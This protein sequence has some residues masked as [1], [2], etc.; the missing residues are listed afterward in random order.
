MKLK[1]ALSAGILLAATGLAGH[2][3]TAG[4]AL[5]AMQLPGMETLHAATPYQD[6]DGQVP[7]SGEYF[8]PLF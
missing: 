6:N 5:R 1:H 4:T 2:Q 3:A 7:S 8:G